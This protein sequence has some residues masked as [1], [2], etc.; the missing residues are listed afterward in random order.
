[1]TTQGTLVDRVG[2]RLH[3]TRDAATLAV[4]PAVVRDG[5][6][7]VSALMLAADIA[8]GIRLHAPGVTRVLT[9]SFSF[10]R[11]I[12][13]FEG[14]VTAITTRLF[15]EGK[16]SVDRLEFRNNDDELVATGRISFVVR[17]G[18]HGEA[19]HDARSRYLTPL[20]EPI[21]QPLIEAAGIQIS[22]P[23]TGQVTMR[24]RS[25]LHREGGILQGGFVT[26]LGEASALALAEHHYQAPAIVESLD[27]EFLAG[28][29]GETAV[30]EARWLATTGTSDIE[31]VLRDSTGSALAIFVVGVARANSR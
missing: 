28:V 20:G 5:T 30:T 2:V 1:M 14:P 27:V 4:S 31:V 17:T 10:R 19:H 7:L 15:T 3:P 29:G 22:E 25:D 18:Q 13:T 6:I 24:T 8:A 26:L 16:R 9:T 12:Q 21:P 23:A 11:A